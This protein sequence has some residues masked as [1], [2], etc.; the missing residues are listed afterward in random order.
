MKKALRV[1]VVPL[2]ALLLLGAFAALPA[3]A[4]SSPIE[5]C[6]LTRDISISYGTLAVVDSGSVVGN[7]NAAT[8][9]TSGGTAV[10]GTNE[11][12]LVAEWG[13]VCL[14]NTINVVTDWIFIFLIAIAV[15]LIVIAGFM[16]LTSGG[17]STRQGQAK[18]FIMGAVVGIVIALLARVVPAV[19]TGILL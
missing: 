8:V 17:D 7:T 4:Q 19:V 18:G 5:S 12:A 14:L 13:T 10:T 3:A 2:A 16:Y 11:D 15:V 9:A 1:S 6:T